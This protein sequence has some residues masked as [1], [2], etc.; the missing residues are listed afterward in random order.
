MATDASDRRG[1]VMTCVCPH[2]GRSAIDR[3]CR[4][5]VRKGRGLGLIAEGSWQVPWNTV[6]V[7]AEAMVAHRRSLGRGLSGNL[8]VSLRI[9]GC[10]VVPIPDCHFLQLVR[11]EVVADQ[12]VSLLDQV[13]CGIDMGRLYGGGI[14]ELTHDFPPRLCTNVRRTCVADHAGRAATLASERVVVL[15][16]LA[17]MSLG[18]ATVARAAVVALVGQRGTWV[19]GVV[20]G[21]RVTNLAIPPGSC[22]RATLHRPFGRVGRLLRLEVQVANFSLGLI[23]VQERAGHR[24]GNVLVDVSAQETLVVRAVAPGC[25]RAAGV[26]QLMAGAAV[27]VSHAVQI[28]GG[29]SVI[30]E[31][32]PGGG[33]LAVRMAVL[34]GDD[35]IIVT[36]ESE[37]TMLV[38]VFAIHAVVHVMNRHISRR[39]GAL[40]GAQFS[41]R[42]Q[43][44]CS[45]AGAAVLVH[46]H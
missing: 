4:V 42:Q 3:Q 27:H 32:L 16:A 2:A 21:V 41:I 45:D 22:V 25:I 1:G 20:I 5:A 36:I 46:R 37:C 26:V 39:V 24:A 40:V 9:G 10:A 13:V 15:V 33:R 34:A 14:V 35:Q 18:R 12:A 17:A 8:F 31:F 23:D 44:V 19:I 6:I 28:I 29:R 38:A 11:I 43:V 30:G 7:A